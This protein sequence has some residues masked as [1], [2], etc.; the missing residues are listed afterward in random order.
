M[1]HKRQLQNIR[2]DNYSMREYL[3]KI[4]TLCDL[5]EAACHKVSEFEQILTILN[6][7]SDDYEAVV[8]VIASNKVLTSVEVHSI[9]QAHEAR[10]DNKMPQ[11]SEFTINYTTNSKNKNQTSNKGDQSSQRGGHSN[12]SRGRG[13]WN[14]NRPKC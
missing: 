11:E 2:K 12:R 13:R 6:G 14:N 4:K 8:A 1:Y 5:L 10:I 9:L 3:Y 7:L